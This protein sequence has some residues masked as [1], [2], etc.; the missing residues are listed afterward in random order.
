MAVLPKECRPDLEQNLFGY[1][2]E[3]ERQVKVAVRTDGNVILMSDGG[4]MSW[5]LKLEG[6][7][8]AGVVLPDTSVKAPDILPVIKQYLA[9]AKPFVAITIPMTSNKLSIRVPKSHR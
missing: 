4:L 9:P 2:G 3:A 1:T 6:E 7:T 5:F 8:T